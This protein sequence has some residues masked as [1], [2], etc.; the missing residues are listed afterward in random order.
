MSDD[1]G[2]AAA[3]ASVPVGQ[4]AVRF[5]GAGGDLVLTIRPEDAAPMADALIA[6]AQKSPAFAARMTDAAGHV[7][8][9]KYRAGLLRCG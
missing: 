3:V 5:I 7:I 6:E 9:A 8:R 4:R 2:A 1:L